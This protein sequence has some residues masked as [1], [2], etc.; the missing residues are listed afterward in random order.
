M[1]G[2]RIM[3]K[4]EN[5]VH[6]DKDDDDDNDALWYLKHPRRQLFIY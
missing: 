3:M 4:L 2:C 5:V 6:D 1:S